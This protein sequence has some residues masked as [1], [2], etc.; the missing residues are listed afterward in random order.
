MKFRFCGDLDAPDWLLA[1]IFTLSKISSVRVKLLTAQVIS[2]I[3]TGNIDFKK[4]NKLV[5]DA[6]LDITE[7]KASLEALYFIVSNAA[8]YDVEDNQLMNELQ[9]LGLPKEHCESLGRSYKEY[10]PKLHSVLAE[11]TLKLSSVHD[12]QWRVDC[13]VQKQGQIDV[14]LPVVHLRMKKTSGSDGSE[15]L[16]FSMPESKFR[17]VFTEVGRALS[18]VKALENDS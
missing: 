7:K 16:L 3:I 5:G 17:A 1:E 14:S 4:V 8:K 13:I 2:N 11:N 6:T 9:Q 12:I 15:D 10:K 18:T